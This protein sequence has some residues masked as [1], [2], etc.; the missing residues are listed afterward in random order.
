[1]LNGDTPLP[2]DDRGVA[3]GD[4]LFETVLVR[5]GQPYLWDY[6]MARLLAG[7]QRLG[8]PTPARHELDP[9]PGRAGPGLHVFK[10]ILTRG[11]GGRGYLPPASPESRLR[12][13]YLPFTANEQRWRKGVRVRHCALRL[14][15][16][17]MLA[18]LKHLNR[19]ENV[20]ARREWSDPQTAEGL[21]CD[22][23]GHLV[24]A[25]CMN[26]FWRRRGVL[27]TPCLERCGVAGTLR[28]ALLEQLPMF[29]VDVGPGHLDEVE[30][31]WLG[32][33][34]Q[35]IWPVTRLDD[36]EGKPLVEWKL[37]DVHRE[38]QNAAQRLLGYPELPTVEKL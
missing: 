4:G 13:Q 20:L 30:A 35:G 18:G 33:S 8:I 11:S 7:C 23:E 25:T 26:V 31:L 19:L 6:H 1:M 24:E 15:I 36:V 17:P 9:L 16:Q 34:V 38:F 14:S 32:N 21:L 3:Y 2:L 27:E 22:H 29:E 37:T 10:L 28:Q 12:W 5:D